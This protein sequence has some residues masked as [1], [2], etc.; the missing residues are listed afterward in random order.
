MFLSKILMRAKPRAPASNYFLLFYSVSIDYFLL[1]YSVAT[2]YFIVLDCS[3][4]LPF[5]VLLCSYWLLFIV[6]DCSYG[7]R[8]FSFTLYVTE[9]VCP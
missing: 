9:N 4:C 3:Y 8:C 6:L 2:D 1:F 7:S 5:I